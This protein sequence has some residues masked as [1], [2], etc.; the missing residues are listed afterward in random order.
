MSVLSMHRNVPKSTGFPTEIHIGSHNKIPM[1]LSSGETFALEISLLS[2]PSYRQWI[3]LLIYLLLN[4][5]SLC[6]LRCRPIHSVTGSLCK[7]YFAH[8]RLDMLIFLNRMQFIDWVLCLCTP[9]RVWDHSPRDF[10]DLIPCCNES[11]HLFFSVSAKN[12]GL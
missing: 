3:F 2:L 7:I 11:Q 6:S 12:R 8:C 9:V 5:L 4:V 1:I 10:M